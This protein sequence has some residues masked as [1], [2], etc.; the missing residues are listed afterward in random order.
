M[1]YHG[2]VP[3]MDSIIVLIHILAGTILVAMSSIMQLIVGPAVAVLTN[4]NEKKNLTEKLKKR[5]IPVMDGAIGIQIITAFYLLNARWNMIVSEPVLI[6]KV[7][8][9]ITALSLAGT[10]HFYLRGKKNRL[11]KSGK[12]EELKILNQKTRLVEPLVLVFGSI[13]YFIGIYFNHM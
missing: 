6:I 9:G 2:N 1:W 4:N 11:A 10:A 8:A 13:A 12:T 7:L 5:R 3:F